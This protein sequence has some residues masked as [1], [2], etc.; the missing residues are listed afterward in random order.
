MAVPTPLTTIFTPAPDCLSQ[1]HWATESPWFQL[2]PGTQCIPSGP[3]PS[4]S[5]FYSPG[6]YCPEGYTVACSTEVT[7]GSAT[8]TRATCCPQP[9][10]LG[11]LSVSPFACQV[12][13]LFFATSYGCALALGT[14]ASD[15]LTVIATNVSTFTSTFSVGTLDA[16]NA[17]SVQI[18]WQESDLSLTRTDLST[19]TSQLAGASSGS[20]PTTTSGPTSTSSSG[21]A[22][23]TSTV[24][25]TSSSSNGSHGL[26]TGAIVAIAV[27]IPVVVIAALVGLFFFMR[28]K[29]RAEL[30]AGNL[31]DKTQVHEMPAGHNGYTDMKGSSPSELDSAPMYEA[32]SDT[33]A[34]I[35]KG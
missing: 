17:Y 15:S 10:A 13:S 5:S 30:P 24:I 14:L 12:N 1:I 20:S 4:L 22:S 3:N 31:S 29:K 16:V 11:P 23:S 26:S 27:V 18:R 33:K 9:T 34:A 6:L 25:A 2:G 28:R 7:S 8:E 21:S 32:G 19:S 35:M